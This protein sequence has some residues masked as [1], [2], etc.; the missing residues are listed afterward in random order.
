MRRRIDGSATARANS[1]LATWMALPRPSGSAS[2]M[3]LPTRAI[4]ASAMRSGSSK[5][6]GAPWRGGIS[7]IPAR[8]RPEALA[9]ALRELPE[10]LPDLG[11]AARLGVVHGSA[12]ERRETGGEDHG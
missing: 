4:T 12:A 3:L 11:E 1:A 7:F 8:V 6:A 2:T 10:D 5:L 9:V